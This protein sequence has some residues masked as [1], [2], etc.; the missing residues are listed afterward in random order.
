[1]NAA[2]YNSLKYSELYIFADL[3]VSM[4]VPRCVQKKYNQSIKQKYS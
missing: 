2:F 4:R 3:P 1:V